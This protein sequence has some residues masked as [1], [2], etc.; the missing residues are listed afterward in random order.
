MEEEV[1]RLKRQVK[2]TSGTATKHK[3]RLDEL[4]AAITHRFPTR[5]FLFPV[6]TNCVIEEHH[7]FG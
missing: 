5:A 3:R 6:L 7:A 1:V 4:N 2:N